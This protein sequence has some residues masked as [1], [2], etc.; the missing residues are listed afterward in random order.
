[1]KKTGT[2]AAAIG[3]THLTGAVVGE[4]LHIAWEKTI[5]SPCGDELMDKLQRNPDRTAFALEHWKEFIPH[6]H[7]LLD[8]AAGMLL[9]AKK[10]ARALGLQTAKAGVAVAGAV[11]PRTGEVLGKTGALNHPAWGE[12]SPA[13]ELASRSKLD[14]V[15]LNDGKAMALGAFATMKESAVELVE[16]RGVFHEKAL[17]RT[18]MRDFIEIDPGTGLG[19]AYVVG[20]KIW[21]GPDRE[22]PDPTIGEIWRLPVDPERLDMNFEE[23]VSGRAVAKRVR[24]RG[25][26]LNDRKARIILEKRGNRIQDLLA[27]RCA[28]LDRIIGEELAETGRL[29][30]L[31]MIYL[32]GPERERLNAPPIDTFVIGGGLVSGL[33][34]ESTEVRRSIYGGIIKELDKHPGP[35]P[36]VLFTT[37]GGQAALIGAAWNAKNI[38]HPHPL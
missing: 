34:P 35:P 33:K 1:M 22:S 10:E 36:R 14:V 24:K 30:A 23:M 25:E 9:E 29:I 3:G 18:G 5:P 7:N 27:A 8:A 6:R 13:F 2:L 11:D 12:F 16:D 31:G 32:I 21:Y 19:G 28:K 26:R 4:D 20:G 17:G 38:E 37:L 15:C